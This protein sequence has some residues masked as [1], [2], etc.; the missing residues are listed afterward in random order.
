MTCNAW[1]FDTVWPTHEVAALNTTRMDSGIRYVSP[2]Q[3]HAGEDHAI[4]AARHALY[5][6]AKES[7]P[8]RWSGRAIGNPSGPLRSI[9]NVTPSS[10]STHR[11]TIFSSWLRESGDN[12]LDARSGARG[13]AD[14]EQ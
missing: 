10:W 7:H 3:R 4:L 11:K 12:Y 14:R 13:H 5:I 9:Q 8:A 2:Q 1:Y 6:T